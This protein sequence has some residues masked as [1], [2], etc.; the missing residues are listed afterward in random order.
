MLTTQQLNHFAGEW[1]ADNLRPGSWDT[2]FISLAE[3]RFSV[4]MTTGRVFDIVVKVT[5][6]ILPNQEYNI[7]T[8]TD[9][10]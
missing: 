6:D 9:A 7:D 5:V 8:A 10:D 3:Q 2:I 1:C 4:Y